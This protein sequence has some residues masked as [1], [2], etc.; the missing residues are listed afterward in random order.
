MTTH[1]KIIKINRTPGPED[2]NRFGGHPLG[3]GV[4]DWPMLYHPETE[5][6]QPM[7]HVLTVDA[8]ELELA[9]PSSIRALA[10]FASSAEMP[11]YFDDPTADYAVVP[12]TQEAIDKG[13]LPGPE[14]LEPMLDAG[15]LEFQPQTQRVRGMTFTGGTPRFIQSDDGP[16]PDFVLQFD[17]RLIPLNLGDS[18]ALYMYTTWAMWES[19]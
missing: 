7:L 17:E 19:H 12:L 16:S 4:E 3:V 15:V 18:G 14:L 1:C 13:E 8:R 2:I 5:E 9:V 11:L 6:E 10:L